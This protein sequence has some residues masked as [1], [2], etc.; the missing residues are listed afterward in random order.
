[1]P[2]K[3]PASAALAGIAT[4]PRGP[5][6]LALIAVTTADA[7]SHDAAAGMTDVVVSFP[8]TDAFLAT[9]GCYEHDF[10]V[11][12]DDLSLREGVDFVRLLKRRSSAGLVAW[13]T[14]A[15]AA[16]WLDAGADL[17][18]PRSATLHDLAAAVRAVK[19]RLSAAPPPFLAVQRPWRLERAA[20]RLQTPL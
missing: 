2:R 10:F 15:P 18:L 12:G 8:D 1:M 20:K 13:R 11:V 7:V 4:P 6:S 16:A 19:R 9:P 14:R 5:Y 3:P 17:W